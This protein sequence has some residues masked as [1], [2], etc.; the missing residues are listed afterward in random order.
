MPDDGHQYLNHFT[1]GVVMRIDVKENS[2][3]LRYEEAG[4]EDNANIKVEGNFITITTQDSD[5]DGLAVSSICTTKE[6]AKKFF[7]EAIK[8]IENS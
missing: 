6:K 5:Y 4:C 7:R 8:M 2:V 3:T 1:S